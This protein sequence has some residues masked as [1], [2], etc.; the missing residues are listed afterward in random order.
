MPEGFQGE[1]EK[2]PGGAPLYEIMKWNKLFELF[3]IY[4]IGLFILVFY[5]WSGYEKY[6]F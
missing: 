5:S 4:L 2:W 6:I 1:M 3:F